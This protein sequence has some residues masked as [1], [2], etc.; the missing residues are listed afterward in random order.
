MP[1]RTATNVRHYHWF[2]SPPSINIPIRNR[3][4][5]QKPALESAMKQRR[6]FFRF[7]RTDSEQ[8][9]VAL[10]GRR[11]LLRICAQNLESA[12]LTLRS[13]GK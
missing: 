13:A 8:E 4:G 2:R 11:F 10:R 1:V 12:A 3:L 9:Y 6:F 5:A 7:L